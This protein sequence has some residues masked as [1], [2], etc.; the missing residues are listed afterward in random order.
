MDFLSN[1]IKKKKKEVFIIKSDD[2]GAETQN[3]TFLLGMNQFQAQ[4]FFPF[5][6]IFPLL[7][8]L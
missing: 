1:K 6:I 4:T 5:K 3:Q 8:Y 7:L 2:H